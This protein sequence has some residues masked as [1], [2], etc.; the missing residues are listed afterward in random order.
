M[1]T[2][3]KLQKILMKTKYY[4]ILATKMI[5]AK[6]IIYCTLW[7]VALFVAT[8]YGIIGQE[9]AFLFNGKEML[10]VASSHIFPMIM[11]MVLYLWDVMYSVSLK[12]D[13]N[14]GLIIGIL[15]TIILFMGMFVF[16]LLVNNNFWGWTLFIAAWLS[17]T[18]LKFITTED[19][20][21]SPYI[22]TEE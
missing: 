7:S 22:I 1:F 12:R 17:L 6:K 2:V 13:I 8:F 3:K 11:A 16:S 4:V 14:G 10:D 18:V 15:G 20:Q 9:A 19:E 5:M 21:S